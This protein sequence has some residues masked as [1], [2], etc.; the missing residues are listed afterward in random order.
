MD[1]DTRQQQNQRKDSKIANNRFKIKSEFSSIRKTH[2]FAVMCVGDD[3]GMSL[4][5]NGAMLCA[6]LVATWQ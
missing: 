4:W 2:V 5:C 6:C 1:A 3:G